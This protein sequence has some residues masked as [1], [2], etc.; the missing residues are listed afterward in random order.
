VRVRR[1]WDKAE[2][3]VPTKSRAGVR[4]VPIFEHPF[5]Y[6]DERLPSTGFASGDPALPRLAHLPA[7]MPFRAASRRVRDSCATVVVAH[8]RFR[9]ALRLAKPSQT[10]GVRS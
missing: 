6:L 3:F 8:E 7:L 1:S 4:D 10:A 5:K 2:G 9:P